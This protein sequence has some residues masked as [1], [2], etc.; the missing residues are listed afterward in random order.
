MMCRFQVVAAITGA[1][2]AFGVG[3]AQA[4]VSDTYSLAQWAAQTG[5][6]TTGYLSPTGTSV[7]GTGVSFGSGTSSVSEVRN[8]GPFWSTYWSM[9]A[10]SGSNYGAA[11]ANTIELL[12]ISGSS[13]TFNVSNLSA[14]GFFMQNNNSTPLTYSISEYSAPNAAN[15]SL[16]NTESATTAIDNDAATGGSA[17]GTG[18]SF[19]GYYG[20]ITG[21][22]QSITVTLNPPSGQTV[23]GSPMLAFGQFYE[24]PVPEPATIGLVGFGLAALGMVRRRKRA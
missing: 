9:G 11:A 4:A 1:V 24:V 8:S 20:D 19:F 7:P 2:L 13:V 6:S 3:S 17:P 16:I 21:T 14:F 12:K 10:T 15:G 18:A 23:A 5:Q 22:V